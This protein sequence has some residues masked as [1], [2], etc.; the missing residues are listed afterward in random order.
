MGKLARM[1][2][3]PR[4]SMVRFEE[5]RHLYFVK[6]KAVGISVTGLLAQVETESFDA[7]AVAERLH[8]RPNERYNAGVDSDG[9]LVPMTVAAIK[10]QW[11]DAR[12]LG[13][14]LHGRIECF[15]NGVPVPFTSPVNVAEYR[16]ALRWLAG[17]GL[18]PFRSEWVIFDEDADVAGSVDF[19]A[20]DPATG[21]LVIVDWK[22]CRHGPEVYRFSSR[23]DS[24]HLQPPL[25]HLPDTT[26]SHWA[27][28]VNLYRVIIERKYGHTVSRMQMVCLYP[29]QEEAH[30]YVHER[31]DR[32]AALLDRRCRRS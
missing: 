2:P 26:L 28:Q 30:V 10:K 22:R 12:D 7:D 31:D 19:V 8:V 3:H 21:H 4:D 18:E 27:A 5:E 1:H 24:V 13:T 6:G 29:G 15:L 20:R 32:V 16:Q 14:D 23:R 17:C 25:D 9:Q 11:D